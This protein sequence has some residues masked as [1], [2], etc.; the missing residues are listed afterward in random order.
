MSDLPNRANGP[1]ALIVPGLGDSGPGHWQSLFEQRLPGSGRMQLTNWDAPKLDEW[2][3]AL[4]QA[5]SRLDGEVVIVAHSLG[6]ATTAHWVRRC[7]RPVRAAMFVAPAD[8]DQPHRCRL[9][10]EFR[11]MPDWKLPFRSVVLT[12]SN[13]VWVAAERAKL[14]AEWWGSEF[15]DFGPAGHVS[16]DDGF[17]EWPLGWET[18][19]QLLRE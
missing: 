15:V 12:S 8:V 2:I 1:S 4:D 19:Q 16:T 14:F 7:S 9:W 6:C 13:D 11:P 5:Y 10:P 3:E 17:G 18:L